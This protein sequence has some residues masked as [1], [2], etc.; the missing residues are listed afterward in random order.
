MG[1]GIAGQH[2][3]PDE[4]LDEGRPTAGSG[5]VGVGHPARAVGA[6]QHLVVA[7]D[8][9]SDALQQRVL[10]RRGAGGGVLERRHIDIAPGF[11]G[12]HKYNFCFCL[13]YTSPSPRDRTRYRMPSSA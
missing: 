2:L 5:V 11:A 10:V 1:V 3:G 12:Q 8:A 4:V 9:L 13:L 6:R 7:D